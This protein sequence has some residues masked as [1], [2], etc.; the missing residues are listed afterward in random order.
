[1]L[2]CFSVL[3][4]YPSRDG[5][6]GDPGGFQGGL[7][8]GGRMVTSRTLAMLITLSCWPLWRQND[9]SW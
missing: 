5:D 9:R 8:I 6:E 7:Q 1:M 3:V 4:Q 2:C